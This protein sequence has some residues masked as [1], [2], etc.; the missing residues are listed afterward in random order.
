MI[1]TRHCCR[2]LFLP[3]L[4]V[5]IAACSGNKEPQPSG[6][7]VPNQAYE[8]VFSSNSEQPAALY[9]VDEDGSNIRR[10]VPVRN[11]AATSPSVSVE[12]E[13]IFYNL[14]YGVGSSF[15]RMKADGSDDVELV[16]FTYNVTYP[17]ISPDGKYVVYESRRDGNDEIYVVDVDAGTHHR[18]TYNNTYDNEPVWTPDGK[19]VFTSMV[20]GKRNIFIMDRDGENL[21]NLKKDTSMIYLA[22]SISPDGRKIAFMNFFQ[23]YTMNIDGTDKKQITDSG[24]Q[25]NISPAWSP[26]GKKIAFN[27]KFGK[28]WDVMVIN[29]DGTNEQRLTFDNDLYNNTPVWIKKAE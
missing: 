7:S 12:G 6:P 1:N 29:A 24:M 23:I 15:R 26:D 25:D 8:I 19:I 5:L 2:R 22:P 17:R 9:K 11:Y 14:A 3:V 27:R 16:S 20:E 4:A 21:R 18:L 28:G 10:L 13:H